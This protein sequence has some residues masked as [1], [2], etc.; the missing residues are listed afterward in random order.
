MSALWHTGRGLRGLR[1]TGL[2]PERRQAGARSQRAHLPPRA[3]QEG[4]AARVGSV[5]EI[6]HIQSKRIFYTRVQPSAQEGT[7]A[8]EWQGPRP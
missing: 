6:T 2:K 4:P 3:T 7:P 1:G 8:A 5:L